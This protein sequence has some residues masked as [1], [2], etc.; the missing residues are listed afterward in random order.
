M[1]TALHSFP[2]E[3]NEKANS[4]IPSFEIHLMHTYR[5]L[6]SPGEQPISLNYQNGTVF[7]STGL[8][9]IPNRI[10]WEVKDRF[11]NPVDQ[12]QYILSVIAENVEREDKTGMDERIRVSITPS[13][14]EDATGLIEGVPGQIS[15]RFHG[16]SYSLN[17]NDFWQDKVA[18][19]NTTDDKTV[20]N[21]YPEGA[22]YSLSQDEVFFGEVLTGQVLVNI[23][24]RKG[25]G[26]KRWAVY[27]DSKLTEES[28]GRLVSL[29]L[30]YHLIE[31]MTRYAEDCDYKNP[32]NTRDACPGVLVVRL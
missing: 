19:R 18:K 32:E 6:D 27:L 5:Y 3:L 10:R 29:L 12:K 1:K 20:W 14:Q 26:G 24:G 28:K 16:V 22:V 11:T 8:L 23:L 15:G 21:H 25:F 9:N 13:E 30:S 2:E 7:V 4:R 31:T 17:I